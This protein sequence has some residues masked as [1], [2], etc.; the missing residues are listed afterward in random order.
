MTSKFTLRADPELL[1]R[2][3]VMAEYSGMSLNQFL[4]IWLTTSVEAAQWMAD[5]LH[6]AQTSP[7]KVLRRVLDLREELG[8]TGALEVLEKAREAGAPGV[9]PLTNRGGTNLPG[10]GGKA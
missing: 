4:T 3:R 1:D 2:W 10:R 7:A 5:E 8:Q 6:A 9:P